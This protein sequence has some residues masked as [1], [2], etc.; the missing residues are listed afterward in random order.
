MPEKQLLMDSIAELE[1]RFADCPIVSLTIHND[2]TRLIWGERSLFIGGKRLYIRVDPY[3]NPKEQTLD[4][5]SVYGYQL[6][7]SHVAEVHGLALAERATLARR[8][9]DI[10]HKINSILSNEMRKL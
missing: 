8:Y 4:E 1:S 9:T 2:G 7:L 3:G 10:T 6:A 5:L